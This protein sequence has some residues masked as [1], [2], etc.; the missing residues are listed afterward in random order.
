MIMQ[1]VNLYQDRLKQNEKTVINP[2]IASVAAVLILLLGFSIYLFIDRNDTKNSLKTT[3][4]QLLAAETQ[5]QL[6]QVKYPKQQINSLLKQQIS[7]SQNT[8]ASLSRII[9]LLSDKSSDQTQGFSRYFTALAQQSISEVWLRN[10]AID[11]Q[12]STL[13]LQGSSYNPDQI[14][15]LLQKL[16]DETIFQGKVFAK[17]V[18]SQA[19]DSNN[20]VD[21]TVSTL[22]E[23]TEKTNHD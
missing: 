3:R 5:V 7:R 13:T 11:A 23:I 21:F 12:N 15:V 9:K 16:H 14:A 6:L 19:Q 10:I 18:I 2:Y 20:Q 8:L 17:L 4:Q 1:Q 22:T